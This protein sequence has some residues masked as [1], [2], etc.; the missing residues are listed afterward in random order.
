MSAARSSIRL[1]ALSVDPSRRLVVADARA[2]SLRSDLGVLSV[3]PPRR[4]V[5]A[6]GASSWLTT[7]R[8]RVSLLA[9]D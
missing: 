1:G 3:D 8:A 2:R 5:V 6:D 9:E 7:A 4:L